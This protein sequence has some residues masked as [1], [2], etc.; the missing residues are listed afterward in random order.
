MSSEIAEKE[1]SSLARWAGA[2]AAFIRAV[3]SE[4]EKVT[5]PSRDELRKA[6][7]MVVILSFVLGIA[8]GLMDKLLSLVLVDGVAALTR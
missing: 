3:R 2:T 6:T 5:W 1:P 8:I 7:Q 4:L